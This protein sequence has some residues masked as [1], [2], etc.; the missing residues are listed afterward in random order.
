MGGFLRQVEATRRRKAAALGGLAGLTAEVFVLDGAPFSI[1]CNVS[2]RP[3]QRCR[4]LERRR[5]T[6]A[7]ANGAS[8]SNARPRGRAKPRR[9]M[10][11]PQCPVLPCYAGQKATDPD[12]ADVARRPSNRDG[13]ALAEMANRNFTDIS[14]LSTQLNRCQ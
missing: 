14:I 5:D 12:E 8:N 9:F 4:L 2:D 13:R 7:F 10:T 11:A 3:G 6:R 1:D